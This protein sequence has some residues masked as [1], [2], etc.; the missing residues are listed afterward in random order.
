MA[1]KRKCL[2]QKLRS[3][4]RNLKERL[5]DALADLDHERLVSRRLTDIQWIEQPHMLADYSGCDERSYRSLVS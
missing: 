2:K 3:Q 1:R 5:A 4:V